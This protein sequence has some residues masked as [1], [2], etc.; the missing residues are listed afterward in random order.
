MK[1]KYSNIT[2]IN[3]FLTLNW[4][5]SHHTVFHFI[6]FLIHLSPPSDVISNFLN[7]VTLLEL[8]LMK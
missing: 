8:S 6:I 1:G 5:L 4:N 7:K 3:N 2:L